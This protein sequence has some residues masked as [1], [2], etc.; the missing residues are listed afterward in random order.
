MGG[1]ITFERDLKKK[2]LGHRTLTEGMGWVSHQPNNKEVG[3]RV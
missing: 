2:W 1:Y 3:K